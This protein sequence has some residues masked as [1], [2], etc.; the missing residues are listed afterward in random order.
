MK[1]DNRVRR[2]LYAVAAFA[3][4][5]A[6]T[7]SWLPGKTSAD[8]VAIRSITMSS[9]TAG[10]ASQSYNVR[11]NWATSGNVG[12]IVVDFCDNTPLI[13]DTTC[14]V[15]TGFTVTGSPTFTI[16]GGSL[17]AGGTWTAS[18]LNSGQ[19]FLLSNATPQSMTSGGTADFVITS[20]TNPTTANHS[21]YARIVTYATS[22]AMTSGYTVSG[23][24]RA[25]NP[26]GVDYGGVALSTATVINITARVMETL[27]F[28]VYNSSCGDDPSMTIGN[29]PPNNVLDASGIYTDT[30]NFS[31]S[32]NAQNGGFVRLKGTTLISG[33]NNIDAAGASPLLFVAGTESF[34]ATLT[35]AGTNI[36]AT[37]PYNSGSADTYGFDDNGTTGTTSTYGDQIASLSGPVNNSVSTVT[38]AAAASNTTAAGIYTSAHQLIMTGT[39]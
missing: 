23:T 28:C 7:F 15:P 24:T 19:V 8:Q 26:G 30:V 38:Y 2:G 33:A 9:S 4:V 1:I 18:S 11:F 22:A 3:F 36:T 39:F 29:G 27:S 37:S 6:G 31:I 12:G 35:T 14:D 16:N 13:G 34:G 25:A 5:V 17:G 21:F 10:A 32:T 20:V